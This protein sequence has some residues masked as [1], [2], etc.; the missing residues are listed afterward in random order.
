M[1]KVILLLRE[2]YCFFSFEEICVFKV[3]KCLGNDLNGSRGID[4]GENRDIKLFVIRDLIVEIV[5]CE[6]EDDVVDEKSNSSSINE[7]GFDKIFYVFLRV[8]SFVFDFIFFFC[9]YFNCKIV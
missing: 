9:F 4:G 3:V 1:F 6:E 7:F 2:R 8:Y 5:L